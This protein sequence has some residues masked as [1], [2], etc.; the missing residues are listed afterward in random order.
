[1]ISLFNIILMFLILAVL[2]SIIYRIL[3]MQGNYGMNENFT[4]CAP[5]D[6]ACVCERNEYK[7]YC[8][9]PYLKDGP[10]GL[11]NC[12]WNKEK[13]MCMGSRNNVQ[14]PM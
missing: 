11:C 12:R 7:N 2:T 3:G 13:R 6:C 9:S 10:E 14:C 8:N 1:M 5:D 4:F